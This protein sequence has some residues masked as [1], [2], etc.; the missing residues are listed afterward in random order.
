MKKALLVAGLLLTG[1]SAHALQRSCTM[2]MSVN[3]VDIGMANID[4]DSSLESGMVSVGGLDMELGSASDSWYFAAPATQQNGVIYM[5]LKN[6]TSSLNAEY[7]V[8]TNVL[9]FKN[10]K[11]K[12]TTYGAGSPYG[13]VVPVYKCNQ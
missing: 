12:T 3:K 2:D 9:T 6:S 1:L 11:G 5:S 8:K 10:L 7:N 13:D 4:I